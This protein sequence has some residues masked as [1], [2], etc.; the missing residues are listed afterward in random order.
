MS[1]AGAKSLLEREAGEGALDAV[2]L[3]ERL[4]ESGFRIGPAVVA[5][6]LYAVERLLPL[7]PQA[8]YAG[9][10]QSEVARIRALDEAARALWLERCID[11]EP[12]YETAFTALCGR[13]DS[14]EW[15]SAPLRSALEVEVA[16]RGEFSIHEARLEF[17][18]RLR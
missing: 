5:Q 15:D 6:M 2:R 11:T 12:E 10:N 14:A 4:A 17:D 9:M 3:F 18:A 13:Q 8:L 7:L 1:I 16:E